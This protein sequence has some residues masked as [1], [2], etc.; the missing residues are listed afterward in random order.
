MA[1]YAG[2]TLIVGW[3]VAR[4]VRGAAGRAESG[5]IVDFFLDHIFM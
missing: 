3:A 4:L 2:L 1:L 5:G